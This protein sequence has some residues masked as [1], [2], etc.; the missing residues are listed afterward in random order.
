MDVD[1]LHLSK[2]YGEKCIFTDLSLTFPDH[3]IYCLMAPSGRGKTTLFRIMAGLE[4]PDSGV[5]R[6]I[7]AGHTGI[8]FQEDRLVDFLDPVQ[9]ISLVCPKST[10]GKTIETS[11]R[12]ILPENC[13]KQ[14]ISELSGG[15][16]RRVSLARAM[17]YPSSLILMDEPFT[18]LD[19]KTRRNVIQY[20]LD[21]KKDRTL[22]VSTH[23]PEDAELLGGKVVHLD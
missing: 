3:G 11:L 20:L 15:M 5:I 18:G 7:R 23:D 16:K 2:S 4:K 6:G 8:V 19:Q 21:L 1:I 10:S 17:W 22:I 12:N 9:N 13:L 14:P